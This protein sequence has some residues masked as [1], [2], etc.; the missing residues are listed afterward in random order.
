VQADRADVKYIHQQANKPASQQTNK[1]N[2][3]A[4]EPTKQTSKQAQKNR[5]QHIRLSVKAAH[6]KP[7]TQNNTSHSER[8]T[9]G[10]Q[11]A[12]T[13]QKQLT[14]TQPASK[15]QQVTIR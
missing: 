7:K 5:K 12:T 11:H 10:N 3:Q 4:I 13:Q 8:I 6:T 9:A 1:T 2:K 14:S 15:Q